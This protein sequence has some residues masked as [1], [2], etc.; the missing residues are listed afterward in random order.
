MTYHYR[1]RVVH[2]TWLWRGFRQQHAVL[3]SQ[4]K[5]EKEHQHY[6][7]LLEMNAKKSTSLFH[8]SSERDYPWDMQNSRHLP[9]SMLHSLTFP[10]DLWWP[11][12]HPCTHR[13]RPRMGWFRNSTKVKRRI[14][15]GQRYIYTS[16]SDLNVE[17]SLA[18]WLW[19]VKNKVLLTRIPKELAALF[20]YSNVCL[21]NARPH[22]LLLP[23]LPR[24]HM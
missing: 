5:A 24:I 21:N 7:S 2:P 4:I 18:K 3:A 17:L 13:C 11:L 1:S 19:I 15:T 23:S 6:T 20:M 8:A 16:L 14:N 9:Y 22:F 12:V 10:G